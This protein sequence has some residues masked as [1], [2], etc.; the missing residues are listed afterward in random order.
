MGK[1]GLRQCGPCLVSPFLRPTHSPPNR[2]HSPRP[3]LAW[4]AR[5]VRLQPVKTI[6]PLPR[7]V[8]RLGPPPAL[9]A[10]EQPHRADAK[11]YP[12]LSRLGAPLLMRR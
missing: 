4:P 11:E 2:V 6:A 3:P 1:E 5:H 10:G 9:R 8:A 7:R 12:I